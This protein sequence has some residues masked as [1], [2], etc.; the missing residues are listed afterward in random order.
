MSEEKTI[1]RTHVLLRAREHQKLAK[2]SK[3]SGLSAAEIIRLLINQATK[4]KV[5]GLQ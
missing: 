2:L 4:I 3:E 5:D 1:K